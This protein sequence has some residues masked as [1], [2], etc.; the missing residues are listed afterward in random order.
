MPVPTY[1]PVKL[2]IPGLGITVGVDIDVDGITYIANRGDQTVI[3]LLPD[4][5]I[6]TLPVSGLLDPYGLKLDS[7]GR[8]VVADYAGHRVVRYDPATG[9]Q[10]VVGFTGL[11]FPTDVEIDSLGR[12]LVVDQGNQRVVRLTDDGTQETLGTTQIA[13]IHG[14]A[15]DADDTIYVTQKGPDVPGLHKFGPDSEPVRIAMYGLDAPTGIDIGSDGT[16]YVANTG[17]AQHSS[18]VTLFQPDGTR[19]GF[20]KTCEPLSGRPC[21]MR[22]LALALDHADNITVLGYQPEAIRLVRN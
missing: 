1:T 8:I 21:V 22:P 11:R 6:D 19:I 7:T 9:S 10:E 17:Q 3:R 16:I 18:T 2:E 4:G 15:L 5:D 20:V 14:I 12:I 13:N